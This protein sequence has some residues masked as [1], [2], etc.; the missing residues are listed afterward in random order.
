MN[1]GESI[2]EV[3]YVTCDQRQVA[4]ALARVFLPTDFG[5]GVSQAVERRA[6]T[7]RGLSYK[8]NERI[9][10]H[11]GGVVVYLSRVCY[12][13]QAKIELNRAL[14][15]KTRVLLPQYKPTTMPR[16]E[17]CWS[18]GCLVTLCTSQNLRIL[19]KRLQK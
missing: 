13:A 15:C 14:M 3:A 7:S 8:A 10:R 19:V 5:C 9:A 12:E 11:C 1:K 17:E 16:A 18:F 2:R 6:L 4:A